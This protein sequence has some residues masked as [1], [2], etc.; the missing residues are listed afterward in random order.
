ML[1]HLEALEAIALRD[2]LA[3]GNRATGTLGLDNSASY[4]GR[5]L[6]LS[7]YFVETLEF[8]TGAAEGRNVIAE[9]G[10]TG[11]GVIV[12]GAH[13]DSVVAGPGINDNGSGVAALL[14]LADRIRELPR[15]VRTIRFAFWGAEEGGPFGSTAYVASLEPDELAEI[16]A[17][18]NFDM[19]GSPNAIRF[20]Y[21]EAD[22]APG[23]ERLTRAFAAYFDDRDLP[24]APIDLEGDSD[25]GP[26]TA[27]GIPTGGLFS[28]GIEHV[29]A[30]QAAALRR[31]GR[32]AGRPV[33]PPSV[34][35][36]R[37]RRPRHAG[38]DGGRHR[39]YPRRAR[40][41]PRLSLRPTWTASASAWEG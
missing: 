24:W 20:V 21:A 29:T 26:F 4:V 7:D 32:G 39:Q 28:G 22:A 33:Q 17:Y 38:R 35:H 37:E 5:T 13:L 27:A 34:R 31:G 16:G 1:P 19:I 12:I 41:E 8:E 25:H 15:P 3:Q 30:D 9:L 11:D 6:R 2:P 14:A 40:D 18:L 36:A 10:G 23:S